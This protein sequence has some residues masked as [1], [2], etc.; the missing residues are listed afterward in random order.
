MLAID[1]QPFWLLILKFFGKLAA[2]KLVLKLV[3]LF[4]VKKCGKQ[5]DEYV[6]KYYKIVCCSFMS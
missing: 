1:L 5:Y 6:S 3:C 4:V 2:D